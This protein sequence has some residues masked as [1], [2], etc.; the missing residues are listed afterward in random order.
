[1][2]RFHCTCNELLLLLLLRCVSLS[3]RPLFTDTH[4][5][6]RPHALKP[7]TVAT[8]TPH[9]HTIREAFAKAAGPSKLPAFNLSLDSGFL[10]FPVFMLN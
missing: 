2:K 3:H 1:M 8:V 7:I 9:V 10:P 5:R 6:L 4:L